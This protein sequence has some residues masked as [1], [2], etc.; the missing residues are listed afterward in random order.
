MSGSDLKD[1][2]AI[3]TLKAQYARL[4]DD[5]FANPGPATATALADIFTQDGILDLGPFGRYE[6]RA[7]L[8]NAFENILPQGTAWS[9]HYIVSPILEVDD[10]NDAHGSWYFLIF[11]QPRVQP[12]PA[13]APIWGGYNDKYKKVNGAWKIAESISFYRQPPA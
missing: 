1:L 2:E 12:P 8:L 11:A 5:V 4:A 3:R 7:A 6:G 10:H 9:I 13:P